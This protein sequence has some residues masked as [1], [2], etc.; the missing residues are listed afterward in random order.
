MNPNH[1][2]EN[3]ISH[4]ELNAFLIKAQKDSP[5]NDSLEDN[6]SKEE[7]DFNDLIKNWTTTSQK[8]LLI[9]N[10]KEKVFTKNRDP[11]SLMAFGAMG[12]HINMALQ[13][14]KATGSNQ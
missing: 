2:P 1:S 10:S 4:K 3:A 12:A 14:H 13:A 6:K 11:K 7:E 8:I 5:L 9:M